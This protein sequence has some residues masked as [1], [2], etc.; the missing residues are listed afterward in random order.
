M[1][2]LGPKP[3]ATTEPPERFPGGADSVADEEKYGAIPDSPTVPDLNPDA[4]P[5]VEDAAP[6]EVKEPDEKQQEPDRGT[7]GEDDPPDEPA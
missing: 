2:E 6:D 1:D 5:A 4:N 3:E 7:S